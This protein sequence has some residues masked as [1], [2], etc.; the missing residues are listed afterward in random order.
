MSFLSQHIK[1]IDYQHDLWLDFEL[2]Y[3]T[4]AVSGRFI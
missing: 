3:E 1:G 2:E 4:E